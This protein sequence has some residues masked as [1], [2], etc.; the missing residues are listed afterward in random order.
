M[1]V[2]IISGLQRKLTFHI[3]K[4][5]VLELVAQELRK[6]SKIAKAPG[7]RPGKVPMPLIEK[8]YGTKAYEDALNTSIQQKFTALV[9]ENQLELADYPKFD[10]TSSEKEEF[11]LAATFEIMPQVMLGTLDNIEIEKPSCS[12]NDT[13]IADTIEILRKQKAQYIV[14]DTKTATNNDQVNIDFTGTIN[15]A[16]FDGSTATNYSFILGQKVMLDEFENAIMGHKT[17]D[18]VVAKVTFPNNYQAQELQ[19]KH[20]VFNIKLNSV[21][22]QNLPDMNEEFIKSLGVPGGTLDALNNAIKT[23][24][25]HEI[26]KRVYDRLK[27]NVFNAL[28]QS[29]PLEV[30][31][32]LVDDE[33]HRMMD[34]AKKNIPADQAH[35]INHG[36]FENMAKR[37][38]TIRMLIQEFIKQH[39]ITVNDADIKLLITEMATVYDDPEE[40]IKHYYSHP[41]LLDNARAMALENKVIDTILKLSKV[42]DVVINYTD[43]MLR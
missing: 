28:M 30:P 7:F 11:I 37:F 8:M 25:Q 10:M 38:V 14:D 5:T 3:A 18:T 16:T 31:H 9:K 43:L 22:I 42:K 35:T 15:D 13:N 33:I 41:H 17:G 29:S 23:S 26:K 2:E 32:K 27:E 19:N 21:A 4:N 24:M 6:Y 36:T 40:Y 20:A 1:S 34:H 12:L 39:N